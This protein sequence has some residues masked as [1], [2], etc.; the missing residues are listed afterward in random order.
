MAKNSDLEQNKLALDT[1]LS[2]EKNRVTR[3]EDIYQKQIYDVPE[4]NQAAKDI[5]LNKIKQLRSSAG[6]N[7]TFM[8]PIMGQAGSGKTYILSDFFQKTKE[9]G[10]F[11]IPVD[12]SSLNQSQNLYTK[13]N[14]YSLDALSQNLNDSP[15]QIIKL[16][17]NIMDEAGY[18]YSRFDGKIQES[19]ENFNLEE[20][21]NIIKDVKDGLYK[22]HRHPTVEYSDLIQSIFFLPNGTRRVGELINVWF[23]GQNI[24]EFNDLNIKFRNK[25]PDTFHIFQGLSWLMS[26]RGSFTVLAF[27]QFDIILTNFLHIKRSASLEN[28]EELAVHSTII[29]SLSIDLGNIYN[30]TTNVLTV[31]TCLNDAW[32]VL[33]ENAAKTFL[34][35]LENVVTLN[36]PNKTEHLEK[37]I[38][39]RMAEASK[40][41]GFVLPYPTWPF[42]PTFFEKHLHYFP[43]EILITADKHFAKC[44]EKNRVFECDSL[45]DLIDSSDEKQTLEITEIDNYF[46]SLK[47]SANV[48]NIYEELTEKNF[49]IQALQTYA[50]T[51]ELENKALN[52]NTEILYTK[53]DFDKFPFI[54]WTNHQ[55]LNPKMFHVWSLAGVR[56]GSGFIAIIKKAMEDIGIEPNISWRRLRLIM[57]QDLLPSSKESIKF[58]D[59]CVSKGGRTLNYDNSTISFLYALIKTLEKYSEGFNRWVMVKNPLK[60]CNFLESDL[61]WLTDENPN[62]NLKP[63][64]IRENSQKAP[65]G[66]G[67]A[68]T[69]EREQPLQGLNTNDSLADLNSSLIPLGKVI[70]T[71]NTLGDIKGLRFEDLPYHLSIMGST[72]SGKTVTLKRIVEEAALRKIPSVIIDCTSHISVMGQKWPNP[73]EGWDPTDDALVDLYAKNVEVIVWTPAQS[74]GNPFNIPII[75]DLRPFK[76]D[77]EKRTAVIESVIANLKTVINDG[78]TI[79]TKTVRFAFEQALEVMS[80][81]ATTFS[82]A[83]LLDTLRKLPE[84]NENFQNNEARERA[85]EKAVE[86]L[87]Q[88]LASPR[89]Q[90]EKYNDI[91]ELFQSKSSKTRISVINLASADVLTQQLKVQSILTAIFS[92]AKQNHPNRLNGLIVIDEAKEFVPGKKST[93]CKEIIGRIVSM[94]RMLGYGIIL[95][96]Q[97]LNLIDTAVVSNLNTKMFG[98]LSSPAAIRVAE[99]LLGKRNLG[100]S[101]LNPGEFYISG[102][103]FP[104]INNNVTKIKTKLS[105]SNH[106]D[107][108]PGDPEL[109]K[110]FCD[111]IRII[112]EEKK[113]SDQNG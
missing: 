35:R 90:N 9:N 97:H 24:S 32:D 3:F 37:L 26:L 25:N 73:P 29:E 23:R 72:G 113:L 1:I 75:P 14:I 8:L 20:I 100:L 94:I 13:I 65:A 104:L 98:K 5:F 99:E 87:D 31:I 33:V 111:S 58:L 28:K 45:Q 96:S 77:P 34:G 22:K 81:N 27:D 66:E 89:Y 91:S 78:K 18:D 55:S 63:S 102:T 21:Q 79:I 6:R 61:I 41:T 38:S 17:T 85:I 110:I 60:S 7:Q 43:R 39:V 108:P 10:G 15:P 62:K 46:N 16:I 93:P 83:T 40:K 4:I 50:Q 68:E 82:L 11:F 80:Q 48:Q 71:N 67:S 59:L 53:G 12:L 74:T 109:K 56:P 30:Q 70:K 69:S 19:F 112:K 84:E 52:P 107:N 92:Y 95:A 51:K 105:L 106:P 47:D 103:N 64:P 2:V 36:A 44:I 86:H 54:K 42:K 76:N 49:W 101:H 88:T 57:T